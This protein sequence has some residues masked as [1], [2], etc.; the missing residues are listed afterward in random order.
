MLKLENSIRWG[1]IL[2]FAILTASA[3]VPFVLNWTENLAVLHPFLRR[4]VWV[5]G[6]FIVLVIFGFGILS[7]LHSHTLAGGTPLA[8]S[9]CGFISVF[10]L[11]RL[12]VQLF[13]FDPGPF[14]GNVLLRIGYHLLT[15]TFVFLTVVYSLGAIFPERRES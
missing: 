13:L 10:W 8:R 15:I 2:H 4:L 1:G 9:L 5:Y 7:V 11:A 3:L 12:I 14:L 6:M